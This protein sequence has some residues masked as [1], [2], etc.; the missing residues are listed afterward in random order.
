MDRWKCRNE[1]E[2]ALPFLTSCL[3]HCQIYGPQAFARMSPPMSSN[4]P[5]FLSCLIVVWICSEPGVIVNLL[6]T[7]SLWS[8]ASLV[9]EAEWDMSSYN[10]LVQDPMIGEVVWEKL[11]SIVVIRWDTWW[12]THEQ[13]CDVVSIH[14]G[15]VLLGSPGWRLGGWWGMSGLANVT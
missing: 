3:S 9:M 13:C 7:L 2:L 5:I 6:L 11:M 14:A 10:E 12:L 15:R 1:L 4:A 8:A